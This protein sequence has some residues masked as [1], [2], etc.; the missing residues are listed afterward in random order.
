MRSSPIGGGRGEPSREIGFAAQ[1]GEPTG[2]DQF[3]DRDLPAR[4]EPPAGEL[5]RVAAPSCPDQHQPVGEEAEQLPLPEHGEARPDDLAV[6]RMTQRDQRSSLIT[7]DVD[8]PS[9]LEPEQHRAVGHL[10]DV[11][12]PHLACEGEHL[13]HGGGAGVELREL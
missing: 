5:H 2:F 7:A 12:E 11:G 4:F 3:L 6:H 8:E 9:L 13:E 1:H 10:L